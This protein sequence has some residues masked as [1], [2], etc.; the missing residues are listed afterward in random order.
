M[1]IDAAAD[2]CP[3]KVSHGRDTVS[4]AMEVSVE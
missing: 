1:Q 2:L 3:L 4:S